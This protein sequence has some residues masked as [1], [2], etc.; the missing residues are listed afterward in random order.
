[1]ANFNSHVLHARE[2]DPFKLA[3]FRIMGRIEAQKRNIPLVIG[4]TE[5]WAW[6]QLAMVCVPFIIE[7]KYSF[8]ELLRRLTLKRV[9]SKTSLRL[10][11][12]IKGPISSR[13]ENRCAVYGLDYC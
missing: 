7:E 12:G 2:V 10:S 13:M 4:S 1:M 3:L 6:F 5:D 9:G 11:Q 8:E